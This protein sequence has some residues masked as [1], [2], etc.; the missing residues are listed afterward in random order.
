MK[1][2]KWKNQLLFNI[3]GYCTR[4]QNYWS[5]FCGGFYDVFKATKFL[6]LQVFDSAQQWLM[7]LFQKQMFT[8][9]SIATGIA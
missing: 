8:K 1:M 5:L 7:F 4:L 2:N 3:Y 9:F 6:Y